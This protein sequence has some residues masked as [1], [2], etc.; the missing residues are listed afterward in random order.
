MSKVIDLTGQKFI[1]LIVIKR[2]ANNKHGKSMWLCLCKC[3]QKTIVLSNNLR[4][5]ASKSCGCYST[6]NALKHGH[7]KNKK[8]TKTYY[9]WSDMIARCINLNDKYYKDYG[10][11][12]IKVCKRWLNSFENFLEDMGE[13]P[14]GLQID[15]IDNN[16]GYYKDNCRWV[17]SKQN[18]RN[19]RNN[20]LITYDGKTQCLSTWAEEFNIDQ[21][22]FRGRIK[23][24]WSMK[25][26]LTTPVRKK[27]KHNEA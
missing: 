19:R 20:R 6:N 7:T 3:G 2:V 14:K 17:T 11:R 23:L 22:V 1:R 9:S 18:S 24:G 26:A 15:R 8:T 10:G 16:K 27:R 12:G 21:H 13:V 4:S 5:G 25:E